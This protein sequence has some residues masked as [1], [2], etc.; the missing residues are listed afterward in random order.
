MAFPCATRRQWSLVAA[1][2]VLGQSAAG[3]SCQQLNSDPK[4]YFTATYV[5]VESPQL[6]EL[7]AEVRPLRLLEVLADHLNDALKL[8]ASVD[9]ALGECGQE[10]AFYRPEDKRVVLCY[11]LLVQVAAD[12]AKAGY[13]GEP[14]EKLLGGTVIFILLHELGH[15]LTD[16]LDLAITGREEDA[17][18]QL[19][20]VL[21]VEAD[22]EGET[23]AAGAAVWFLQSAKGRRVNRLAYA[24]EHSLGPQRYYNILC[25][26]YGRDP[27]R[28]GDLVGP[29][30][31][32]PD[33]A[34]ACPSEYQRLAKSW[35]ALL[36]PYAKPG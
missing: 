13:T 6:K 25:W 27:Q 17:A 4:A 30:L 18:D 11:E 22:E 28:H 29:N 16:V 10:N 21:L 34:A 8:P 1:L 15:A 23:A 14:L 12:L 20:T 31:L 2:A 36:R 9:L 26:I 35:E 5:P 19:A 32:P 7:E 24:D 3:M 33:R